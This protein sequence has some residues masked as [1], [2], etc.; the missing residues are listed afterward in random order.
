MTICFLKKGMSIY[1]KQ[2]MGQCGRRRGQSKVTII[3][4]FTTCPEC[5][6]ALKGERRGA[7]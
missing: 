6:K 7:E 2:F 5:I 1:A 3:R 4:G